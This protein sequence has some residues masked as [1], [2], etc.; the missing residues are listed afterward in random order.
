MNRAPDNDSRAASAAIF[1]KRLSRS[2]GLAAACLFAPL[3][4]PLL[5]GRIFTLDDLSVFHLPLRYLYSTALRNGDSILW[6]PMLFGGFYVHAEGQVGMLHPLHLVLYR[7]FPL[8]VAF[9]LELIASY[10]FAFAGMWL[11]LRQ[12]GLKTASRTVGATTFAFSGFNLLR[13]CHMNVVATAAHLP[14]LLLAC[15]AALSDDRR[16]R[17][18]ALAAVSLIIASQV[19]LGFPQCVWMSALASVIY[20]VFRCRR[21]SRLWPLALAG[22]AGLLV[23]GVQLIPTADLLAQSARSTLAGGFSVTYSLHP[24]NLLQLWCP[25]VF[26]ARVFAVPRELFVHEYGVYNGALCTVAIVWTASRH[27]RMPFRSTAAYAGVLSLV[28]VALALGRYGHVYEP[29]TTMLPIVSKFRGPS[30]HLLLVHCGLAILAAITFEDLSRRVNAPARG[31][32]YSRWLW[33]PLVMSV[34]TAAIAWLR[35]EWFTPI[36]GERAVFVVVLLGIVIAG[37][38]A[39][40]GDGRCQRLA[41]SSSGASDD[42]GD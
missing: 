6:T 23:G 24:F 11:L 15:D 22:G 3:L 26:P 35:P 39:V 34:A 20:A 8:T 42:C 2:A 14:W 33:G 5:T 32:E 27:S 12:V 38:V 1:E 9:N 36:P 17:G 29:L 37:L 13:L 21:G 30:R 25:Y 19:L 40:P 28:G 7:F 41:D 4:I 18:Q 31:G 10:V 16:R